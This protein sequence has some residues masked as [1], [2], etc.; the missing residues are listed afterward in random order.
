L[1]ASRLPSIASLLHEIA[2]SLASVEQAGRSR[3]RSAATQANECR[4][5]EEEEEEEEEETK[6][7]LHYHRHRRRRQSASTQRGKGD[8]QIR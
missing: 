6:S 5:D 2:P 4:G 1:S 8:R 3:K 7:T